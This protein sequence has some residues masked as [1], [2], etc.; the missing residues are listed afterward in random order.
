MRSEG[1]SPAAPHYLER[2]SA[3][4]RPAAR[5]RAVSVG[6][7]LSDSATFCTYRLFSYTFWLCSAEFKSRSRESRVLG[8]TSSRHPAA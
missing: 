5:G 2:T 8:A 7:A 4:A 6:L 1:D 3:A